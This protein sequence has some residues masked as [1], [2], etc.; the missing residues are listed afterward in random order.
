[1]FNQNRIIMSKRKTSF[2]WPEG[3]VSYETYK[4]LKEERE[5]AI[6]TEDWARYR[7]LDEAI[8]TCKVIPDVGVPGTVHYYT[9]S[10]HVEEIITPK[11]IVFKETGIYHS[12]Y[13]FTL[14]KNGRWVE[15]GQRISD[16]LRLTLG[17]AHDYRCMEI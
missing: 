6:A 15:E 7:M 4:S 16:G 9:D 1:M 17:W 14:R 5:E 3:Y 11:K 13:T 12:T 8:D 2:E 10:G